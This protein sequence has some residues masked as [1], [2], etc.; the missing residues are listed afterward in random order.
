MSQPQQKLLISDI[1]VDFGV[2]EVAL[3]SLREAVSGLKLYIL[4][5]HTQGYNLS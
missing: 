1:A 4:T 3:N 5:Q 2:F